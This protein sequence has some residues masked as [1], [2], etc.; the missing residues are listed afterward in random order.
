MD[1]IINKC[2]TCEEPTKVNKMTGKSYCPSCLK[3]KLG[4]YSGVEEKEVGQMPLPDSLTVE[5][6]MGIVARENDE[7]SDVIVVAYAKDTDDIIIRSSN[8]TRA[9]ANLMMDLAKHHAISS[10]LNLL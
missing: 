4:T 3:E 10:I 2:S 5:Q 8:M 6:V 1:K 9:E 7:Y